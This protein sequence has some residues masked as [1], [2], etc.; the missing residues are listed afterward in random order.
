MATESF[1]ATSIF[2]KLRNTSSDRCSCRVCFR[3]V[4]VRVLEDTLVANPVASTIAETTS[5]FPMMTSNTGATAM[6]TL[7]IN[8]KEK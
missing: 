2:S 4:A 8:E 5:T 1:C 6:D 3:R 7:P